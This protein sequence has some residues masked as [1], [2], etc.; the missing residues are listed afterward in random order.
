MYVKDA[1]S[2][3]TQRSISFLNPPPCSW[4]ASALPTPPWGEGVPNVPTMGEEG[5]WYQ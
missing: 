2:Q 3:T 1:S 4:T 5:G